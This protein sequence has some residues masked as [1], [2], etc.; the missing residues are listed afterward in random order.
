VN[1][2]YSYN[3]TKILFGKGMVSR[4]PFEFA[5]PI[6]ILLLYGQGS[7]KKNG[8]Y[9][10]VMAALAGH[11][12][13]EFSG[14]EP[15]PEYETCLRAVALA[16]QAGTR[17][18]MAVGG[19]SVVDAAKF[20]AMAAPFTGDDPWQLM[21]GAV[22]LVHQP[23]PFACVQT[24]PASGSEM[25]NALVISRRADKAKLSYSHAALYPRFSILDPEFTYSLTPSQTALGIVDVFTHVMEQYA[26]CANGSYLQE[27]QAE[28]VL[29]TLAEVGPRLLADP[30]NYD[31]R[32]AV[33][34][35][36][37]QAVNGTLSRGV[38]L[39]WATHAIGHELTVHYGMS[40]AQTLAV[41]LGGVLR[42]QVAAKEERLAQY[43]RRVWGLSGHDAEV[44]RQ[45][46]GATERFFDSL[47]VATRL[48]T[49]G[50]D[51]VEV[52]DRVVSHWS[53]R[54]FQPLGENKAIDL[55]AVSAIIRAQA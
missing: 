30:G 36:A 7:I 26:T 13:T 41:L 54:Q 43:G 34:W 33:M 4:L 18:V 38:V 48:S 49:L 46:I 21:T 50:L 52:A 28:A 20:V 8:A 12:V 10:Q 14:I 55:Q 35:S 6:S 17:F 47:G 22:K 2:F 37:T 5:E 51:A 25:N 16:R 39:D 27:R 24:L 45:A 32:A 3:P 44:A 1:N 11:Q 31:Y 42:H 29:S 19:G 23:L 9:D 15:N 40:H 53:S